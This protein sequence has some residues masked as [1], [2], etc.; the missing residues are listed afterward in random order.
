MKTKELYEK[1]D[2]TL[3]KLMTETKAKLVKDSFKIASKEMNQFSEV[4][5]SRKLIARINTVLR[6]REILKAEKGHEEKAEV[7]VAASKKNGKTG[8]KK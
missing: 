2:K 6:Q 4:E 7:K 3:Q 8:V 1:D 5:K